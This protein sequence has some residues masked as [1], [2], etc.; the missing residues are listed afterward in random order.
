MLS[1]A[2]E[3]TATMFEPAPEMAVVTNVP[4]ISIAT[5]E[6]DYRGDY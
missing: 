4:R 3:R 6:E 2:P 5:V 1:G